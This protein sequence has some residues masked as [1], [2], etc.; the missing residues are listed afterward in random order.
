MRHKH[1]GMPHVKKKCK[2]CSQFE[3]GKGRGDQ[4]LV[5]DNRICKMLKLK[6]RIMNGPFKGPNTFLSVLGHE[7]GCSLSWF[8]ASPQN[9]I[10]PLS[11]SLLLTDIT[12]NQPTSFNEELHCTPRQSYQHENGGIMFCQNISVYLQSHMVVYI[13]QIN[14]ATYHYMQNHAPL[15]S[16]TQH[17]IE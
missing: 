9:K 1:K 12:C 13:S 14:S 16:I 15:Y 17:S 3:V 4:S 7:K 8:S 5:Q 11:L 6:T 10:Y 2:L